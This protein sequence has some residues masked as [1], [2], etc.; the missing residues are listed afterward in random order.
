MT[1]APGAIPRYSQHLDVHDPSWRRRACGIIALMMVMDSYK[2]RPTEASCEEGPRPARGVAT[3]A[4]SLIRMGV[5]IGAYDPMHGWRH[6]G[7]VRLARRSGFK[8]RRFDFANRSGAVAFAALRDELRG[9]P[10]IVSIHGNLMAGA[11]GHLVV[12]TGI[13]SG[14]VRYHDPD[15]KSR[16]RIERT[17]SLA[18]FRNGWRRRGIAVRPKSH[19]IAP[20]KR[21]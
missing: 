11:S 3:R 19:R 8:S 2:S 9:G 20:S 13:R 12:V 6:A 10:V 1:A 16:R 5:R 14:A 15:S 18:R 4:A 17:A 21:A 7:L